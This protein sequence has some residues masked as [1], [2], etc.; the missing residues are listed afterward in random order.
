VLGP[1]VYK[2]ISPNENPRS[3]DP[4]GRVGKRR[5]HGANRRGFE[6][7]PL[8]LEFAYKQK[9]PRIGLRL[10]LRLRLRL[11]LRLG[12]GL[13]LGLW[14]GI[15]LRLELRLGLWLRLGPRLLFLKEIFVNIKLFEFEGSTLL[16]LPDLTGGF[17]VHLAMLYI[18]FLPDR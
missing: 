9:I 3:D 6:S 10:E 11:G 15:G 18:T 12:I 13:R 2:Y 8:Q 1:Q 5:L 16:N 4:G 7:G 17:F 14:L